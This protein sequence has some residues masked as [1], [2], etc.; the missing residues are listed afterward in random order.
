MEYIFGRD[1]FSGNETLKT[2]GDEHTNLEGFVETVRDYPDC[3][4]TDSFYVVEKQDSAEDSEGGCYDWYVIDRHN[5]I[6]DKTKPMKATM[7]ILV[8]SVL[9]G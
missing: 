2:K 1:N 5:R 7:D 8:A 6:I 4:I 3:V 9:E